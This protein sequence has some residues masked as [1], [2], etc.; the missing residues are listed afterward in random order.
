LI[1]GIS[2]FYNQID[3][4]WQDDDGVLLGH[5]VD[6]VH[7][8]IDEPRPFTKKYGSHKLR[9]AGLSYEFVFSTVKD[10][11]VSIVGPFMAGTADITIFRSKLKG[12]IEAKQRARSSTTRIIADSGYIEEGLHNLLSYRNELDPPE[13]GWFKD[14]AL[15]RQERFHGLI[16]NFEVLTKSFRH[17]RGLNPDR[18]HPRH[19]AC[20]EAACV[21]VQY[22]IDLGITTLIDAYP[23]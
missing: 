13:I 5:T 7:F 17:D 18:Q 11:L 19:K 12:M 10:K 4:Y 6:C 1:R 16:Q 8:P 9:G 3:P 21:A 15:S 2:H 14:R 23:S 22:E 20:V